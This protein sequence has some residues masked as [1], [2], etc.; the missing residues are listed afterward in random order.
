MWMSK[1]ASLFTSSFAKQPLTPGFTCCNLALKNGLSLLFSIIIKT[2]AVF[3]ACFS[4]AVRKVRPLPHVSE[5]FWVRNFL[6]RIKNFYVHTYAYSNRICPSWRI[7]HI[8]GFTLLPR[9]C[10]GIL[11]TEHALWSA[12][13]LNLALPWERGCHLEYSIHGEELGSI[14]LRHEI[15]K[16]ITGFSI[17][18]IPGS[19]SVFRIY[20]LESRLKCMPDSPDTCERKPYPERKSCGFKKISGSVWKGPKIQPRETQGI[21]YVFP[22]PLTYR[23]PQFSVRVSWDH[24]VNKIPTSGSGRR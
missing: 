23:W 21:F 15:K 17:H 4:F 18:M 14:F 16:L 2:W 5:Y 22:L 20:T 13:I 6:W 19:Y 12:Q 9:T 10:L 11:V 1:H 7:R 8:S 3:W 24:S